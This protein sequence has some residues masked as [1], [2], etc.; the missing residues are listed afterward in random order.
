MRKGILSLAV[1]GSFALGASQ[2]FGWAG[3]VIKCEASPGTGIAVN[4]APGLICKERINKVGIKTK[5]K[6][7][8]GFDGC[9]SNAAAP[10][11]AWAAGKYAKTSS[12]VA[13]TIDGSASAQAEIALK[14]MAFG[15]CN[16]GGSPT[17]GAASGGGKVTFYN[18]LGKKAKGASF[19]FFGN[20]SGDA[21]TYSAEAKGL[22]VKGPLQGGRVAITI[23][24][25]LTN[26][27]NG[28]LLACN[29]G[30][31]CNTPGQSTHD[32]G[33]DVFEPGSMGQPPQEAPITQ[34]FVITSTAPGPDPSTLIVSLG[35]P[36]PNDP[37]DDYS[38]IP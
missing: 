2:A 14:G 21:G 30:S 9:V 37:N 26:P 24:L 12:T 19:S 33:D 20:I 27:G 15:S 22:I 6:D 5:I 8:Q 28:L 16:L 29:T 10:W 35:E 18:N 1:A 23:G 32:G 7:G 31:V 17:S 3:E 38:Y 25:D 4:F 13:A 36:D 34:I 11:D